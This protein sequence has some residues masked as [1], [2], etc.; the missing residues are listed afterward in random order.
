MEA[1]LGA[2]VADAL[3]RALQQLEVARIG[4]KVGNFERVWLRRGHDRLPVVR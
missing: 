1:D 2:Q 4:R 3:D